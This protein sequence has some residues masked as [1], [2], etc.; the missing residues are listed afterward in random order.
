[1][2]LN[3]GTHT[4]THMDAPAHFVKNGKTIDNVNLKKCI[5]K[6]VVVHLPNLKPYYEIVP[7]D[8]NKLEE[9]IKI[10]SIVLLIQVGY[11]KPVQRNF[12]STHI[13]QNQ[14]QNI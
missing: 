2:K 13:F 8:F 4:G 14:Q 12:I 7:E 11:I 9:H 10:S 5:G 1:M 3:I 6:A